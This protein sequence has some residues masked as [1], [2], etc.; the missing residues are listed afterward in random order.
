MMKRDW[1]KISS[2]LE[3]TFWRTKDVASWQSVCPVYEKPW[4]QSQHHIK[5]EEVVHTCRPSTVKVERQDC[6]RSSSTMSGLHETLP[7]SK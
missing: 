1:G 7:T 6:S 3:K 4:V 5:P 2:L